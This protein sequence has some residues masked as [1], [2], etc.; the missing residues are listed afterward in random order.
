MQSKHSFG[1]NQ[2]VTAL[3]AVSATSSRLGLIEQIARQVV[4]VQPNLNV[5]TSHANLGPSSASSNTA[6]GKG[7]GESESELAQIPALILGQVSQLVRTP[8]PKVKALPEFGLGCHLEMTSHTSLVISNHSSRNAIRP[9]A[10]GRIAYDTELV[11]PTILKAANIEVDSEEAEFTSS[12]STGRH[13]WP[14][15]LEYDRATETSEFFATTKAEGYTQ[16]YNTIKT[17]W[18]LEWGSKFPVILVVS[19]ASPSY[20]LSLITAVRTQLI[21]LKERFPQHRQP[22][23]WWFTCSEWFNQVYQPYLDPGYLTGWYN[24]VYPALSSSAG[25][26][27]ARSVAK[28]ST[29][30]GP[31]GSGEEASSQPKAKLNLAPDPR[32]WL[33]LDTKMERNELTEFSRYLKKVSSSSKSGPAATLPALPKASSRLRALPLPL[34]FNHSMP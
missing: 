25:I 33:P 24:E 5:A 12:T 26:G 14:F 19:E 23:Q 10:M 8:K 17:G 7:E 27:A 3:V 22:R 32:I 6:K 4:K 29:S 18:P 9:D 11:L 30:S 31:S 1:I 2:V 15:V 16:L 13:Y 21:R 34:L 20:L 28:T